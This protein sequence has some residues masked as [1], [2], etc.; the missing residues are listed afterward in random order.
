MWIH[1]LFCSANEQ[2]ILYKKDEAGPKAGL[3]CVIVT[4]KRLSLKK[5]I[6]KSSSNRMAFAMKNIIGLLML[7]L[8]AV[9]MAVCMDGMIQ[10]T[11]ETESID[12]RRRQD[13]DLNM[14]MELSMPHIRSKANRLEQERM[15]P[16][17]PSNL[18]ICELTAL[19]NSRNWEPV[20]K[21]R[22]MHA[23][24]R[25]SAFSSSKLNIV[26]HHNSG[27]RRQHMELDSSSSSS[28]IDLFDYEYATFEEAG[29]LSSSLT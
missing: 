1:K 15:H 19:A 7:L 4:D 10:A 28:E 27:L 26:E 16:T 2:I 5:K 13:L 14:D 8:L 29:R 24:K 12:K 23:Q 18:K 21:E 3:E 25:T 17:R 11:A 6:T 9:S 20:A 22:S